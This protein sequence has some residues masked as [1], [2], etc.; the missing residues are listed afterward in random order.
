METQPPE[1]HVELGIH[2][3]ALNPQEGLYEVVLGVNATARRAEKNFFLVEAQQAGI[4][5]VA[6]IDGEA[7]T[8]TL[9]ISCAHVLLPFV[10]EVINALVIKGGFPPLLINPMNFEAMYEQKR[11][12]MQAP[13]PAAA[14]AP[15]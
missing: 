12:A 1:V 15:H 9:E 2:H 13:A 5:R 14:P 7:L 6:G 10:R 8:K 3:R 4:F 11:A